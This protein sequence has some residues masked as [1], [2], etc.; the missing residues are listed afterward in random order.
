MALDY[1]PMRN[2]L[3]LLSSLKG[4]KSDARGHINYPKQPFP[5]SSPSDTPENLG[6]IKGQRD[7]Q[8][9]KQAIFLHFTYLPLLIFLFP[10]IILSPIVSCSL[11]KIH[12]VTQ[13]QLALP[14]LS[15]FYYNTNVIFLCYNPHFVH[16][17]QFWRMSPFN[18]SRWKK[19]SENHTAVWK[20]KSL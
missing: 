7:H 10:T 5:L 20:K 13:F 4:V 2:I 8:P 3:P 18:N 9:A 19:V 14:V 6:P 17:Q 11:I 12:T 16:L 15:I 1:K